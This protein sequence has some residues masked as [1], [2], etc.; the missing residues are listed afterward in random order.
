MVCAAGFPR[1]RITFNQPVVARGEHK[2][3]LELSVAEAGPAFIGAG[4]ITSWEL[5]RTLVEMRQ[6][7]REESVLA[8]MPRMAQVWARKPAPSDQPL[9]GR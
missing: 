9:V 3:F 1:P 8:I 4:L 6:L 2:R 7:A 5:E